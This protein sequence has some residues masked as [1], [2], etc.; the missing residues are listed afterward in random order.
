MPAN[1]KIVISKRDKVGKRSTLTKKKRRINAK[2]GVQKVSSTLK[3]QRFQE[4]E[5]EQANGEEEKSM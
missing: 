1:L 2:H 3:K 5:N 4:R